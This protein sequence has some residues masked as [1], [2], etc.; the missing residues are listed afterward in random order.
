MNSNIL[1]V[2]NMDKLVNEEVD[3]TN[4]QLHELLPKS[5]FRMLILGTSG[6]GKSNLLLCMVLKM[7]VYDKVYIYSKHLEQSKYKF[8]KQHLETLEDTI[9]KECGHKIKILEHFENTLDKLPR[10]EDFD[11]DFRNL[12]I[13]DDFALTN[14]KNLDRIGELY[15]RGRHHGVSTIFLTQLYFRIPRDFRL[16]TNYL[17]LF[18]SYNKRELSS[19]SQELGG[20]LPK[21]KF[22][23]LYNTILSEPYN[24]FYIDNTTNNPM[25]RYR[26][27]FD[28]LY[29][30]E[31]DDAGV[32]IEDFVSN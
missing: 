8:L 9:E 2:D 4:S 20:D 18:N 11:K 17:A 6:A 12:V 22:T 32:K 25:R 13:I 16:N 26:K 27:N 29:R 31:L 14:K 19:L 30:G 15:V 5:P 1:K 21:G 28:G 3:T 23:Q 10:P 24:F 7:L